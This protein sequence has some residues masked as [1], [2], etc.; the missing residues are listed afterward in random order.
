[1]YV[2]VHPTWNHP[3]GQEANPDHLSFLPALSPYSN[4]TRPFHAVDTVL[5]L[6]P[7]RFMFHFEFEHATMKLHHYDIFSGCA[8]KNPVWIETVEGLGNACDLMTKIAAES[9]GRS[10]VFCPRSHALRGSINT[11]IDLKRFR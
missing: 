3:R 11:L 4:A 9:P 7:S 1:M 8:D 6:L 10:F 5:T 2:N